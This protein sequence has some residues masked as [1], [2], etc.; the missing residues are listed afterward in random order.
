MSRRL[1]DIV[2]IANPQQPHCATVLLLDASGSMDGENISLLNAALKAFKEDIEKDEL[3]AKRVDLA[4]VAF[5]GSVQ[6]I[7]DFTVIEEF[8]PPTL[9]AS[10]N[11]PMGEAILKASEMIEKRK[12]QYKQKGVDYFRPWIFMITDGEPT[13]M[14]P[15][16][17][18]W[19]EVIKVVHN[20]ESNN[21]F[22][23]FGV[24]VDQ[25]NI[26]ILN[27]ITPPNRPPV[28]LKQKRFKELF[29]WLSKSQSKVSSSNPGEQV[30]LESPVVAGWGEIPV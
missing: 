17:S 21:K 18:K 1:E 22:M 4:V 28:R 13:D 8:D 7:H 12:E 19:T 30:A 24:A 11:T 3:A 10:G 20:G 14:I 5:G 9:T 16:D 2:E 25:A 23:F 15:G 29:E 6:L 27:Q 26:E